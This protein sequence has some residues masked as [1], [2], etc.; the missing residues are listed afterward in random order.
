M[1]FFDGMGNLWPA[2]VRGTIQGSIALIAV[3][4]VCRLMPRLAPSTKSW[5]WRLAWLRV[6]VAFI[7][8]VTFD[9]PV[10]PPAKVSPVYATVGIPLPAA[11]EA[12]VQSTVTIQPA[13]STSGTFS[14]FSVNDYLTAIWALG[15]LFMLARLGYHYR[16]VRRLRRAA[17]ACEESEVV[18]Q[19]HG[20]A[21]QMKAPAPAL[22]VSEMMT[23]PLL[24]GVFRPAIILPRSVLAM[25]RGNIEL[26]LKHELAHLK[27]RDLAWNGVGAVA[28]ILL[29]FNPVIWI[30]ERESHFTQETACDEMALGNQKNRTAEFAGLLVEIAAKRERGPQLL[31]VSVIRTANTLERRLKAMKTIQHRRGRSVIATMVVAVALT[32]TLIPWRAIAQKANAAPEAAQAVVDPTAERVE[33]GAGHSAKIPS[34]EETLLNLEIGVARKDLE[35]GTRAQENGRASSEEIIAKRREVRKLERELASLRNDTAFIRKSL[36]EDIADV[37]TLQRIAAKRLEVGAGT[38]DDKSKVDRE[39]LRLK[40][41]LAALNRT[42]SVSKSLQDNIDP[43]SGIPYYMQN[44]ELMKRYFPQ[45]YSRMMQQG[46][47]GTNVNSGTPQ[48]GTAATNNANPN[49]SAQSSFQ[50]RIEELNRDA[51]RPRIRLQPRRAGVVEA[52]A[53]KAGEKVKQGQE[54]VQFDDREARIRLRAAESEYEIAEADYAIKKKQAAANLAEM[55]YQTKSPVGD[56]S[57]EYKKGVQEDYELK[58]KK[59][60]SELRLASIKV[61]QAKLELED[62]K[63]RAPVAGVVGSF[64]PLPG[65][66]MGESA[67]ALELLTEATN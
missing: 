10:L 44:P 58:L 37:E 46:K 13:A 50:K 59:L 32:P 6:L 43:T 49:V 47:F 55:L 53:V 25:T 16:C 14:K 21:R 56:K 12:E 61:E 48:P 8:G 67:V 15:V 27:R 30:C 60:E 18:S 42:Q 45:I 7:T 38:P 28:H 5:L 11:T 29:W 19:L 1:S 31:T 52:V 35:A 17:M 9:V 64:V 2:I 65:Q 63:I 62:R 57:E 33:T 34:E 40:R 66:T 39:V 20:L 36:A 23:K 3:F 51:N 4:V 26:I 41:E 54:L 22:L 24:M